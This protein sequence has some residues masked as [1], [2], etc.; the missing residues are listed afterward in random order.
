LCKVAYATA[1]VGASYI[2]NIKGTR[3]SVVYNNTYMVTA[4]HTG[5]GNV[6]AIGS[7]NYTEVIVRVCVDSNGN[8][9]FELKD[10]AQAIATSTSQSVS[11]TL[12]PMGCGSIT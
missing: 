3:G 4:H 11:C 8:S 6:V 2:I 5:K 9:Y 1:V 12:V 10:S 7:G